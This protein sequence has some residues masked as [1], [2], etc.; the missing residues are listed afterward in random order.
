MKIWKK[1]VLWVVV[2]A[3]TLMAASVTFNSGG[4]DSCAGWIDYGAVERS[5]SLL[6]KA[7]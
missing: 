4:R 7:G 5:K 1:P 6:R 2:A 3:V